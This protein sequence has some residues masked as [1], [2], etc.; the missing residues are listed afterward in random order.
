M[1]DIRDYREDDAE[2]VGRLIADTFRAFNLSYASPEDQELL[3]G[4]FRHARSPDAAHRQAIAEVVQAPMV[5]VAQDGDPI[6]GVLRDKT[7]RL[8][9]LFVDGSY[10]GRGIGR[11]LVARFDG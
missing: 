5:L 2:S 6:V 10:H 7:G 8:H 9:R 1:V 3:L 4:P 11:Q